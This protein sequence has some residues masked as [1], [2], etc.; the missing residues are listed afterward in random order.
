MKNMFCGFE[1][2][3]GLVTLFPYKYYIDFK[4]KSNYF[5]I[6]SLHTIS[7]FIFSRTINTQNWT[8]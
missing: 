8:Y 3:L 2:L 7:D 5:L 4:T 6:S 1:Q